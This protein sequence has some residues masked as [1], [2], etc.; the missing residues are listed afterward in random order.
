MRIRPK[1][2]SVNLVHAALAHDLGDRNAQSDVDSYEFFTKTLSVLHVLSF[3]LQ[4]RV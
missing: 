4:A 1:V 2:K 3:G